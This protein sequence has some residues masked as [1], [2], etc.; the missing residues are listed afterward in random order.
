[1]CYAFGVFFDPVD[2]TPLKHNFYLAI[3]KS[4]PH[5]DVVLC[6][7]YANRKFMALLDFRP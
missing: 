6:S 4:M 3:R 2:H 1:M 7:F 5:L